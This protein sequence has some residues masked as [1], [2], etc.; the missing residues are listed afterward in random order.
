MPSR[1]FADGVVLARDLWTLSSWAD[2]SLGG[3]RGERLTKISGRHADRPSRVAA[4]DRPDLT[5]D[6]RRVVRQQERCGTPPVAGFAEAGA[7]AR[8]CQVP[9][10]LGHRS[11]GLVVEDES[12]SRPVA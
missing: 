9:E 5:V 7:Y 2:T 1:Q 11:P 6:Q 10:L 3:V 12:G 4:V 8:E